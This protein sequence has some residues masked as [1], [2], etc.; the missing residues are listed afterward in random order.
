MRASRRGI[1]ATLMIVRTQV[2]R[3]VALGT[4]VSL[5]LPG[6]GEGRQGGLERCGDPDPE[7]SISACSGVIQA[8]AQGTELAAAHTNRGIAYVALFNYDRALQEFDRAIA[9]DSKY[10]KAFANRGA[11]HGAKQSFAAAIADFTQVIALDPQ[12]ATAY[13]DRAGM[14][15]LATLLYPRSQSQPQK[16]TR[17]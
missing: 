3:L 8:G 11:V 2:Y 10:T 17:I 15:R 12:S 16:E 4:L 9:A 7:V 14:Y 1:R 13:A 5:S 6:R